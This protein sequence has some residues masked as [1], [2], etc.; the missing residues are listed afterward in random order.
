MTHTLLMA[1][2]AV[3]LGAE[4][5]IPVWVGLVAARYPTPV[6]RWISE[7]LESANLPF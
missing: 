4:I 3:K 1:V 2:G 7:A 6:L 5:A